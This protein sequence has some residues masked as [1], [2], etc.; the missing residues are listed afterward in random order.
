M[1]FF[2]S[3]FAPQTQGIVDAGILPARLRR[4]TPSVA[5]L[6]FGFASQTQGMYHSRH[7]CL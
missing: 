2:A 7:P 4:Q 3:G 1:L 6:A 5:I